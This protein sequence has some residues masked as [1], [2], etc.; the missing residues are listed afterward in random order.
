MNFYKNKIKF[1][2]INYLILNFN[3][4]SMLTNCCP[5]LGIL[6]IYF[7]KSNFLYPL[8]LLPIQ[9]NVQALL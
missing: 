6:I 4:I 9:M 5:P 2:Y 7:M 3:I 1:Y 8:V